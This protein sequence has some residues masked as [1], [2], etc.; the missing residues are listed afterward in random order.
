MTKV[1]IVDDMAIF[2]EPLAAVL[3]QNGFETLV[4]AN[5]R[6]GLRLAAERQPDVILLDAAMPVMDGLACAQQLRGDARLREIPVIMLTAIT[7]RSVVQKAVQIGVQDYLLK[8]Q[9]TT[10]ELLNRIQRVVRQES[11]V[12]TISRESAPANPAKSAAT[13][14]PAAAPADPPLTP[15]D[16]L[17]R[18]REHM[19]MRSIKPVLQ[20]VLALTR[21]TKSS[22]ED[23]ASAIRQDQALALKVMKVAN[24]SFY[25]TN[26]PATT[27]R[28]AEQR[29]GLAGIRNVTAAILAIEEFAEVT[30]AG[31]TPQRFWEHAL[32]TSI[33]AERIAELVGVPR[34]EDLF[35]AGLL[36]DVGRLVISGIL[37]ERYAELLDAMR[38][39]G[40]SLEDLEREALQLNH[41]D[42]TR[43]VLS[44][45]KMPGHVVEAAA[46]H[47]LPIES[48]P[49]AAR[50]PRAT[51]SLIL[52][53]RISHALLLGDSGSESIRP[54]RE[55]A[56]M[57]GLNPRAV[58]TLA[59]DAVQRTEDLAFFY[60]TQSN[61]RSL[62]SLATVLR[63]EARPAPRVFVPDATAPMLEAPL[64]MLGQ[65]QWINPEA[66]SV[67]LVGGDLAHQLHRQLARVEQME[68]RRGK[69][70]PL[71]WV[72]SITPQAVDF[73][74]R[75]V[76]HVT[77][78]CQYPQLISALNAAATLA[79]TPSA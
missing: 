31:I 77:L 15:A 65:L 44:I 7:D 66:P 59:Q 22:F 71:V 28:E 27:L 51:L 19:Q 24:S 14:T 5:G 39:Q 67:G 56:D 64:L 17:A 23:I 8:T 62:D 9:F 45:W 18:I 25:H 43:E 12:A 61:T 38:T 78:P 42:A 37:G 21:S 4:A 30:P 57:L 47:H 48:I 41:A 3:R 11:A 16:A 33:L 68:N 6:E 54:I 55:L 76:E 2:R 53:N 70:V 63:A 36:H 29:I 73:G 10:E 35:L 58:N 72:S 69:R 26:K 1:L 50:A 75:H 20:H 34:P 52:A 74:D 49:Q 32:G 46:L 60:A 40:R 79:F 13:P